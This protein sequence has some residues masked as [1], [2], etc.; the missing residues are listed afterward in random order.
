MFS[1]NRKLVLEYIDI[2]ALF[3]NI[4]ILEIIVRHLTNIGFGKMAMLFDLS[5]FSI[6]AAIII[7][8]RHKIRHFLEVIITGFLSLYSFAQSLHY[9]Y[10]GTFFSLF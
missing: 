8:F 1:K 10:F 6:V 3:A 9:A 5:M 4:I 7:P 2:I